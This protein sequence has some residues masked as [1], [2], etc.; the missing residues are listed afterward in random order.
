MPH[1]CGD[2]TPAAS[3]FAHSGERCRERR[4]PHGAG[5]DDRRI[6]APANRAV[7]G[8]HDQFDAVAAQQTSA[9]SPAS[10]V[11]RPLAI[12]ASTASAVVGGMR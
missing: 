7:A 12:A 9:T 11:S 2:A 1:G 4:S 5:G 3:R 8:G 6:A 10:T